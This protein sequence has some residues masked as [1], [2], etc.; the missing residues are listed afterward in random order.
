M[1]NIVNVSLPSRCRIICI[2]DL[3]THWQETKS[4]LNTA[5]TSLMRT[6]CL[7]LAIFWNVAMIISMLYVM[8]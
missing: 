8:L 4:Y 3:H 1:L 6:I 2:S 5:I 7:Y